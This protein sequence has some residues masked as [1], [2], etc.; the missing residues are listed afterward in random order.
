MFEAVGESDPAVK[1]TI[2]IGVLLML[3]GLVLNY[4]FDRHSFGLRV[5]LFLTIVPF[6]VTVTGVVL[7]IAGVTSLPSRRALRIALLI[8]VPITIL[9]VPFYVGVQFVQTGADRFGECT[10]LCQ[11]AVASEVVPVSLSVPGKP[12]VFCSVERRGMFLSYYN[13]LTVY[14]VTDSV[15]QQKVLDGLTQHYRQAHTNPIQVMFYERENWTVRS[16]KSGVSSGAR[17]PEKLIRVATV[18]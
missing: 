3:S 9:Y 10:G 1:N 8:S 15:A 7:S 16:G 4:I 12:A 2:G 18:G 6:F 13:Q 5:E 17:G 14:G 11:T